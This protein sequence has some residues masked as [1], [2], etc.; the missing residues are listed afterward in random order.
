LIKAIASIPEVELI[1]HGDGSTVDELRELTTR[2]GCRERVRFVGFVDH[3]RL[4]AR[5]RDVDI[6]AVPSLRTT[7]WVE[8][9]GRV[10]VEAMAC[11]VPVVASDDGALREVVGGAGLLV[12]P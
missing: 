7:R 11:G 9:F 5:Y 1:V 2:L 4:P 8:Q 10:A 12:A 6:V 3:D